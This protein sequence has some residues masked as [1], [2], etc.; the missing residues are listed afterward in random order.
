MI[1]YFRELLATLKSIDRRLAKLESCVI[2]YHD[3]AAGNALHVD[4]LKY[5]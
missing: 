5:R 3:R 1:K 4:T 2:V